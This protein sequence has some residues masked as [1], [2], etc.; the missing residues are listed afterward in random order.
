MGTGILL[1][2]GSGD[3]LSSDT[4]ATKENVLSAKTFLGKDTNDD[5][6]AGTMPD[7]TGW[8][9]SGLLAGKSVT[10]PKGY[11]DGTKTV[12][13]ASLASQTGVDSGKTAAVAAQITTGYMAW[14]NGAKVIGTRAT[15]ANETKPDS[16]KSAITAAV[17]PTGFQGFV[18]G[19]KITGTAADYRAKTTA[20]NSVTGTYS[21]GASGYIYA[22]TPA[23]LYSAN[24]ILKVAVTNL[25][26][27]N[28]KYGVTI[29]GVKGT[30]EGYVNDEYNLYNAGTVSSD[31]GSWNSSTSK[32]ANS[33]VASV[34]YASSYIQFTLE[35]GSGSTSDGPSG[36]I[37]SNNY[38]REN[39]YKYINIVFTPS[40]LVWNDGGRG[41]NHI[42]I[43]CTRADSS[44]ATKNYYEGDLDQ[45]KT[46]TF[47]AD[48]E[49]MTSKKLNIHFQAYGR[50][51][52]DG[53]TETNRLKA[54][55]Q[56][57]RI[58]YSMV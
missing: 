23:G 53:N 56:L 5:I 48:I 25:V 9:S 6:A 43:S 13:A 21:S 1:S 22:K 42:A 3:V 49:G 27:G 44:Y 58:Y 28:I 45:G 57:K 50:A 52:S 8:S 20:A 32:A 37:E 31:I 41:L 24:S 19:S 16:G 11:H 36:R 54:T 18:N 12:A 38:L 39:S 35:D 40:R 4:T 46:Y 51:S 30:W 14:V 7:K 47:K 55:I 10:I 26:A 33:N 17:I 15:F 34:T 29:A 2:S